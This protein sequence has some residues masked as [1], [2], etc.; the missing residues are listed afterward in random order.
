MSD[1]SAMEIIGQRR[2]AMPSG[3]GETARCAAW[4]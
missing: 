1:A 3:V 4:W 2:P